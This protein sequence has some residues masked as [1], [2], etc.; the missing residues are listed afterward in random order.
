MDHVVL[1][2]S[3]QKFT[4][5]FKKNIYIPKQWQGLLG[6][7]GRNGRYTPDP[8]EVYWI[9]QNACRIYCRGCPLSQE[10]IEMTDS[11]PRIDSFWFFQLL[12]T[13]LRMAI[14]WHFLYEGLVKA[15]S[16]YWSS[17][18]FLAE[19]K[20]L[21]ADFFHW[22]VA[23]PA[24]LQ[25]VDFLNTAGLILIGIGLLL[26]VWVRTS[27][28]AAILLLILYYL[29]NPA[30]IGYYSGMR[31]EGSYLLIDKNL[32]ELLAVL[33]VMFYPTWG[34]APYLAGFKRTFL[35]GRRKVFAKPQK[36]VAETAP[37]SV[38]RRDLMR[39]LLVLPAGAAFVYSFIKKQ[40]WD[41]F[42]E[43]HL[44]AS[45][46]APTDAV[47]SATIKTFQFSALKDLQG[48][49]PF[50]QIGPLQVSRMILGGNLIGGW[51]HSRDLIYV[52]KLVK[53]YHTDQKVFDT[54]QL[55][56]RCGVNT[57]L[58]N[59]QLARVINAYWR[60]VGGKI[61]FISDCGYR[62][63]VLTGIKMSIDGGAQACYVQ[64]QLADKYV[65]QGRFDLIA[66]ALDLIRQNKMPAGIGGH[67][68]S[69][70]QGCV[71]H[72]LKPDFWVKTLHH[73]NYWSAKPTPE[74]DNIWCT[75]P[76]ETIAYMN[77]LAEPWIAFKTLAAGAI[78]PQVGFSF[79]FQN[80]ADFIC[81]GMYDFQIVDDVN[82]AL[83]V[84]QSP[85]PRTRPWRA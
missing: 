79:A 69:T 7:Q 25:I 80:G 40:Q 4:V 85:M 73:T 45:Q 27:G 56:E 57:L 12:A 29:A 2:K 32:I 42:E 47:T 55:A 78:E 59:P 50:G 60:K 23:H 64:G 6:G 54:L 81:V 35:A 72:G 22:I 66:Q 71:E 18:G 82:I 19:S 48:T 46:L 65:Q 3:V 5:K 20:W 53:A 30:L 61:L 10:D 51:A 9:K 28:V 17:A 52:S 83:K 84:L 37:V 34:L 1:D 41:S 49:L 39:N 14:G 43:K 67:F 36:R 58:T 75:N 68:L 11:K 33:F 77:N 62:E 74:H 15:W 13:L 44:L 70:I 26:G 8:H 76:D 21:L 31:S 63:D 24:A 38:P 16:P